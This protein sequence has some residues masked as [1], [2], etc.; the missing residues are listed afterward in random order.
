MILRILIMD[1]KHTDELCAAVKAGD[2]SRVRLAI[3]AGADLDSGRI[4]GV[5][6]VPAIVAA[7]EG[8][9]DCLR[10]LV[11]A[12]AR[13][14]AE[15]QT[16]ETAA[17]WA[18]IAGHPDCLSL[19]IAGGADVNARDWRGMTVAIYAARHSAN[20]DLQSL[21]MLIKA[22]ADLRGRDGTRKSA[23]A[24]AKRVGNSAMAAFIKNHIA[25]LDER[26]KL[27]KTLRTKPTV[28]RIS[29]ARI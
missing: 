14:D 15:G 8:H 4:M 17:M 22:G 13:V 24:Y 23:E 9:A 10:L 20:K 26:K 29:A 7:M 2:S 1:F 16:G 25:A 12:G 6:L 11:D 19:L 27:A 21:N 3:D 5:K 18:A 28:A